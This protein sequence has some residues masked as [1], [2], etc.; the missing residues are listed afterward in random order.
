MTKVENLN[1]EK[2]QKLDRKSRERKMKNETMF[3]AKTGNIPLTDKNPTNQK[4]GNKKP[5]QQ[6]SSYKVHFS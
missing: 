4:N 6:L 1:L 2:W 3:Y 5:D